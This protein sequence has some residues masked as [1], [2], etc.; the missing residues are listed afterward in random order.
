MMLRDEYLRSQSVSRLTRIF[1]TMANL[2]NED[3]CDENIYWQ[4]LFIIFPAAATAVAIYCG[5]SFFVWVFGIIITVF[6]IAAT[7]LYW[8]SEAYE[9]VDPNDL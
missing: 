9:L 2:Y 7:V 1:V 5:A 8:F 4:L 3:L 6:T